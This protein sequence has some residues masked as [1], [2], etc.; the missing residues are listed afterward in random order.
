MAACKASLDIFDE[1]GLDALIQKREQLV[2]YL[3]FI[4]N[5]VNKEKNNCL[6]I[7]TPKANRGSQLSIVANGY[8]KKLYNQLIENGVIPDWREPNVIRCAAIPLYNS[9]EDMF[10]FGEILKQ[11]L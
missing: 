9:F 7:I 6:Q 1:V 8:G 5:D 10:R 2:A 4:V 11:L 3:E